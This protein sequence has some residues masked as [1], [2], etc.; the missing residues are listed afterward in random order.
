MGTTKEG[1]RPDLQTFPKDPINLG[2]RTFKDSKK[3]DEDNLDL[4]ELTARYHSLATDV[5]TLQTS[6]STLKT[7]KMVTIQLATFN[8]KLLKQI[9]STLA[10]LFKPSTSSNPMDAKIR[11]NFL[12]REG[13]SIE[14]VK[15]YDSLFTSFPMIFS[16]QD[17]QW[18]HRNDMENTE[19]GE[20]Q[21]M[22]SKVK[23]KYSQEEALDRQVRKKVRVE[24]DQH[25]LGQ[26]QAQLETEI[27]KPLSTS[28]EPIFSSVVTDSSSTT[29]EP[30]NQEKAKGKML[31]REEEVQGDVSEHISTDPHNIILGTNMPLELADE[32]A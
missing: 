31:V 10:A 24:S 26:H 9:L 4:K 23:K 32:I 18:L 7:N 16:F 5:S 8:N 11:T 12:Q 20:A 28:A 30:L 25:S 1:T 19:T 3:L 27:S 15:E 13:G 14:N 17:R 29:T 2:K 22:Q 6:V 21:D